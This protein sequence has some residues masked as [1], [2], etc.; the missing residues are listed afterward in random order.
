VTLCI[1]VVEYQSFRGL[2]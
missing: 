2:S 1:V